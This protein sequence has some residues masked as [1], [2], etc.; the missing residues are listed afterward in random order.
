MWPPIKTIEVVLA[1]NV[2]VTYRASIVT[3]AGQTR[4]NIVAVRKAGV[5][6]SRPLNLTVSNIPA[7]FKVTEEG[8]GGLPGTSVKVLIIEI[9]RE[10]K[11]G[12]YTVDIGIEFDGKDYGKIPCTI[13]VVP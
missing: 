12:E 2:T 6:D 8:S 7:G 3:E 1:D 11:P 9:A 5:H 10:V 4:N 13:K